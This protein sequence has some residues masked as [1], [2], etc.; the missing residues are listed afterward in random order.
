MSKECYFIVIDIGCIECGE[1]THI[2]YVSSSLK[3]AWIKYLFFVKKYKRHIVYN[4]TLKNV[5]KLMK[6]KSNYSHLILS[7]TNWGIELH[8]WKKTCMEE[9][10]ENEN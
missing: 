6:E 8:V 4:K 3:N 2:L 9:K 10:N 5:K 1:E 7:Q